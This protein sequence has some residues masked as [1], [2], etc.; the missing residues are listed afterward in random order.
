VYLHNRFVARA[1]AQTGPTAPNIWKKLAPMSGQTCIFR[2]LGMPITILRMEMDIRPFEPADQAAAR[3]LVLRGMGEHWGFVDESLNPDLD[4]IAASYAGD[5][6][7]VG[8]LK[9]DPDRHALVATGALKMRSAEHGEI[10]R[11][12]VARE[13]RRAGA[14]TRMMQALVAQARARGLRRVVLETNATWTEVVAFYQRNGFKITHRADGEF[15]EEVW[16]AR[17]V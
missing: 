13:L 10:A 1:C 12:S 14:G 6:F 5:V 8:A 17:E 3:G 11:M 4:D 15:G 9:D 16:M 2:I 7:L